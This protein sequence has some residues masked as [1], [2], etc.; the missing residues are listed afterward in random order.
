LVAAGV[1][2][3]KDGSSR[4]ASC[5]G[6]G[7]KPQPPDSHIYF[8]VGIRAAAINT[9]QLVSG[10]SARIGRRCATDLGAILLSAAVHDRG[11]TRA[12]RVNMVSQQLVTQW[13]ARLAD[14]QQRL[15]EGRPRPW[16]ARAYVRVLSY[17]LAQYASQAVTESPVGAASE[18]STMKS[19]AAVP[20]LSGKAPRTQTQIRSVLEAVQANVPQAEPGPLIDGLSPDDPIVVAA[21]YSVPEVERLVWMLADEGI[22]WQAERFRR[23]VQISVRRADL[24]RTKP[25]VELHALGAHDSS[26]W[27]SQFVGRYAWQV[28]RIVALPGAIFLIAATFPFAEFVLAGGM[29]MDAAW[30]IA[31]YLTALA[32][33]SVLLVFG[34][35]LGISV[36]VFRSR[37]VRRKRPR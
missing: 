24:E 22:E 7:A 36:G 13:R 14:W 31:M 6:L 5:A 19:Q 29:A 10:S 32:T 17:L 12:R 21:F 27:R 16:I 20:D 18:R 8:W 9:I 4:F 34:L 30:P 15:D 3:K 33:I 1:P 28:A 2:E 25:I 11:E 26:R 35:L 37:S 23:K